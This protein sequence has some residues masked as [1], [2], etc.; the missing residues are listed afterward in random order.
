[1]EDADT[2]DP[3]ETATVAVWSARDS[4]LVTGAVTDPSGTFRIEG[5]RPGPYYVKVSFIGYETE[6]VE[7]IEVEAGS[8]GASSFVPTPS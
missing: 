6:T 8:G 1:M 4:S 5:L 2:G 7:E 3:I